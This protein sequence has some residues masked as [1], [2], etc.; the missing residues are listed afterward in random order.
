MKISEKKSGET[1]RDY[2]FRVIKD[3]IVSLEFIPGTFVSENEMALELGLSRTPVREAIIDLAKASVIETV[4]QRGNYVTLIDPEMVN[5]SR[6]L[7]QVL[8]KA[9]IQVACE[10]DDAD[11]IAMLEENVQLQEF[12]LDKNAGEKIFLLDN[13]FHEGIY[14]I[15]KKGRIFEMRSTLMI[16]FDRVRSL[17]V[18][19]VKDMKIVK[20]HREML[21]AI[22]SHDKEAA[23]ALVDKHLGRYQFDQDIIRAQYPE[24]FIKQR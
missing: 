21:E 5:E 4:P 19:T 8:D 22:K 3:N 1:A 15:A 20:D 12:Y 24:Y 11:G 23:V 16:H 10:T 7:R 14:R 18:E 9:V 13:Q 6:F 17:A 2:A